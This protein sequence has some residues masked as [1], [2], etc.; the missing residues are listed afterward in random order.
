MSYA[1]L[2]AFH[3]VALERSFQKAAERLH[4]TQPAVSIH[5]KNLE[6][7]SGKHLFRR[8]GHVLSLTDDGRILFEATQRLVR[9]ESDARQLLSAGTRGY[10]GTLVIGADGPHVALD[11]IGKFR[12]R[13]PN[14]RVEVVLGNAETTWLNLL[15]LKVD[16]AVL[17]GSPVDSRVLKQLIASQS[18]V[19]LVPTH[20]PL[21]RRRSVRPAELAQHALIFRESGSSTQGKVRQA[22]AAENISVEPALV[23]G[24]REAVVEAVVRGIGIGFVY[25]REVGEDVRYRGV[26]I[27]GCE[28]IN[29]DELACLKAQ[30]TAPLVSTLFEC[31]D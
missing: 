16:A 27:K 4:L 6:T 30:H 21:A 31:I 17:A 7:D 9:A 10:Q 12:E 8:S 5:I 25:D 15:D 18:L 28:A 19:A 20:H 24:S 11:L 23:L 3:A 26:K 29:Q 2:K 13:R 14:V 22:F 1:Q